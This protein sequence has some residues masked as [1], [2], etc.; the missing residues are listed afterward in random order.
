[1][2]DNN[3]IPEYIIPLL[4]EWGYAVDVG[5]N[6]GTFLSNTI[7][8]EEKGWIVLCVEPNPLLTQEGS[9]ARKLWRQVAA[10]SEEK[11]VTFHSVDQ[12]P[13]ASCSGVEMRL[14]AGSQQATSQHQVQMLKL[15]TILEQAGFH[16]LDLATID[17]EGYEPEVLQGFTLERWKPTLL[18][19]E[20]LPDKIGPPEGYE[21]IGRF[22]YDTVFKRL[23]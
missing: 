3:G 19:V 1:V 18:V 7:E 9:Q 5:S 20:S 15:D 23:A 8:L 22:E 17:V 6:N 14:N 13:W 2:T 21:R 10:G 4:P 11:E 16:R 12:Y